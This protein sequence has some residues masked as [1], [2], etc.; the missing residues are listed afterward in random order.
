MKNVI[1]LMT[2]EES[3]FNLLN[4]LPVLS[5]AITSP[6]LPFGCNTSVVLYNR[7]LIDCD[8]IVVLTN[9]VM[10]R[11]SELKSMFNYQ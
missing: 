5:I 7:F 2:F 11:F 10:F 8:L 3:K 1:I 6:I 4:S 9:D